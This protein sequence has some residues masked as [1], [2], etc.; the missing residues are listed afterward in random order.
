[1]HPIFS[2]LPQ[3]LLRKKKLDQLLLVTT[4]IAS[5]KQVLLPL[6]LYLMTETVSSKGFQFYKRV[7][8]YVEGVNLNVATYQDR[9][10]RDEYLQWKIWKKEHLHVYSSHK[11][12]LQRV[13]VWLSNKRYVDE[14]NKEA[15]VHGFKLKMNH[16]GDL[17]S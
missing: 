7:T 12:E 8:P 5:M 3:V 13:S 11:D 1:M 2:H 15:H 6:V 9:L 14:H 4:N 16:F 17:V 10:M